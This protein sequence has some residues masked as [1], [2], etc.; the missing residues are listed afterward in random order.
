MKKIKDNEKCRWMTKKVRNLLNQKQ[1][2]FKLVKINNTEENARRLKN[3]ERK[4]KN[5][6]RYAKK[7]YEKK[8]SEKGDKKPF[9]AYI[10]HK[11]KVKTTV[12]PLKVNN[13]LVS[14][15]KRIA[16]YLNKYFVSVFTIEN[17][18]TMPT[19]PEYSGTKLQ[20]ME[21]SRKQI[22]KKIDRLKPFSAPGPDNITSKM[23]KDHSSS[24]SRAL[25]IIF[26]TS[27]QTGE[28]PNDWKLANVA[29]IH[30]KGPKGDVQN[31]RPISLTSIP[32]KIMESIIKDEIIDHLLSKK[33][34]KTSQHGF[35]K[36]KSTVTNLLEFF[37]KITNFVD[38]GD[39]VDVI[40]LDFSK[41]FDKVP[42]KRL[43]TKIKSS[44]ID[45]NILAWIQGWLTG[46]QQ[47]TVLNGKSSSWEPVLSGVPQGSVLG[48]LAFIIFID[49]ID[50]TAELVDIMNKFADDTKLG[51]KV[52]TD[53]DVRNIQTTLNNLVEWSE[54]WGMKFN[55]EKCS[56]LHLG[57]KNKRHTYNM[58]N[59]PLK[60]SSVERD[61]GVLISSDLKPSEQCQN[62]LNQA[63]NALRN[64]EVSF[65]SRDEKVFVQIY[66]QF[67]RC[68]LEY[69]SQVWS[70]WCVND[71]EKLEKIQKKAV[72]MVYGLN[73]MDYDQKLKKLNLEPLI[74]RRKKADLILVFRILNGFCDVDPNVWFNL[75][76]SVSSR[77]TRN[78]SY[79]LNLKKQRFKTD[80]RKHF[81]SN[82][83]IDE[84]NKLSVEIKKSKTVND[85]KR[86][87]KLLKL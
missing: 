80:I 69:A 23:L 51:G 70:P 46:R 10:R 66:K 41:A 27:I 25:S 21:I 45:G 9:Q 43:L 62:A 28:I 75:V 60:N 55:I 14:D 18:D 16:E 33:I 87:I 11:T 2:L 38:E 86:K 78:S 31:Y 49:D 82:R 76:D 12:G 37:E 3:I 6:V 71:I 32:C 54:K 61:L 73:G 65:L 24:L 29:P 22:Q 7:M 83:I 77:S 30:K 34:L 35:M 53:E 68:H 44:G 20:N 72:N 36:D 84:W 40:Y 26:N 64:I 19:C 63:R 39:P 5:A 81:F 58:N 59:I 17:T 52:K 13:E 50:C 67:V 47:R 42:I 74:S 15:D 8:L 85:F 57:K 4:C 48:P 79:N 1:R 56:V